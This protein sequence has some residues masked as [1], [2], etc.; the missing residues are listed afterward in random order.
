MTFLAGVFNGSP[1]ANNNGDPQQA[2]PS[3]TSFPL[4]GGAL[5][6]AEMQYA[7]P[8]LGT[9]VYADQG[10]PLARAY[11][12][13]FWYDTESFADQRFDND[14]PVARQ[15]LEQRHPAGHRGNYALRGRRPDGLAR[16][17]RKPTATST[18]SS[19]S[20]ARRRPTAT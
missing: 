16:S 5:V 7:Y 14:R 9:M 8:S 18:L 20:W 11:K 12:L 2:N 17:R 10:E 13:G 4:N 19:A 15:S 1:V 6:I 3:G